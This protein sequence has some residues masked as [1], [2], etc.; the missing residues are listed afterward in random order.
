MSLTEDDKKWLTEQFA[1]KLDLETK[2]ERVATKQDLETKLER[3]ATKQDLE[4][5]LE[6]VATKLDLERYATKEDLERIETNLLTAF[7]SW[8]SPTEARLRTHT[9]MLRA[10]D[11]EMEVLSNRISKLEDPGMPQ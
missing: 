8:A 4:T 1:T 7:H 3:V 10:I 5:K 11:L 6:R 9:A 2:L